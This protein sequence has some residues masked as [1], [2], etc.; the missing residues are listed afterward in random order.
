MNKTTLKG[1]VRGVPSC[2]VLQ[3]RGP[4]KDGL[5][6]EKT[7]V[8][9]GITGPSLHE[10]GW[11]ESVKFVRKLVLG[12]R[13]EF[14]IN[15][16]T[17]REDIGNAFVDGQDLGL[18]LLEA[19][20]ARLD[21]NAKFPDSY[22]KAEAK[23]KGKKLG[24][25]G[26]T[27]TTI[28]EEFLENAKLPRDKLKVK[29]PA[30]VE[31][32]AISAFT[33][34][35]PSFNRMAKLSL[36]D[37]K[38]NTISYRNV[39]EY[40]HSLDDL[41]N[42]NACN[43]ELTGWENDAFIGNIHPSDNS[44][45]KAKILSEGFAKLNQ[46]SIT[47]LDVATFR[48]LKEAMESA[49]RENLRVWKDFKA[50]A[51]KTSKEESTFLAKVLE[52][53][54]G[55]SLSVESMNTGAVSRVFL[56]NVR[57][58]S[59]GNLRSTEDRK[60]YA[61]EAR[62]FLRKLLVGKAVKVE[63]EYSKLIPAKDDKGEEIERKF[64]FVSIKLGDKNAANEILAAGFANVVPPRVD[65]DF[66]KYIKEL[67]EAETSAKEGKLGL[68]SGKDV[69]NR[70]F[71]DL[72]GSGKGGRIKEMYSFLSSE[73]KIQGVVE[74]VFSAVKFII[75]LDKQGIFIAV[76]LAGVKSVFN[77]SNMPEYL[78][79]SD[80]G[81]IYSKEC[82]LQRDV[83]VEFEGC[84][85]N[86]V[87]VATL[88]LNKKN[89]GVSV[90]SEGFAYLA[91]KPSSRQDELAKAEE[92][93]IKGKKGIWA[94]N[95]SKGTQHSDT[96][97]RLD[98]KKSVFV[99][100]V[101]SGAEFYVQD[102]KSKEMAIIDKEIE[103]VQWKEQKRLIS[104][105]QRGTLCVAKFS[106]DGLWYRAKVER[107]VREDKYQV[108]FLDF[109]NAD[110]VLISDLCFMPEPLKKFRPQALACALAYVESP[111][112]KQAAGEEAADFIH[113][114]LFEKN[115]SAHFVYKIGETHFLDIAHS[116]VPLSKLMVMQGLAKVADNVPESLA[117]EWKAAELSAQAGKKGLWGFEDDEDDD[118]Y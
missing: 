55:D 61:F 76:S 116:G 18:T 66:S 100:E 113:S 7:L 22:S 91:G 87:L 43:I 110:N 16:K 35:I 98:Y 21:L 77:D 51:S 33:V 68:H 47:T 39:Q 23:A 3:L 38:V 58:P 10:S 90:V 20:L 64:T 73:G 62:E 99:C 107:Q 41:L 111:D 106:A 2:Q 50:P 24:L 26:A 85:P 12:K 103:K 97:E 1:S 72:V 115:V 118:F 59:F 34:Y 46:T 27:L 45:L 53:H 63:V 89:Y 101:A 48:V 28:P 31:D 81:L 40:K 11:L 49:Q 25:F 108:R 79:V 54:S 78:A 95:F 4:L 9:E 105:V 112:I 32:I 70:R 29:M 109:G 42:H 6:L 67:Q 114:H 117:Q 14:I 102:P 93:A 44:N 17:P 71:T 75:R 88:Y 56:A 13:I 69:K 15:S 104:P 37:I 94:T 83:E 60:P 82:I 57:A 74:V 52:V 19:G 96:I 5:P 86:G 65:E 30:L 92:V 84:F 36:A 8:L 80:K